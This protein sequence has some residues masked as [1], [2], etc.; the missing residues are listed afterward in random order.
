MIAPGRVS[1]RQEPS[2][3]VFVLI[4]WYNLFTGDTA[5]GGCGSTMS[6]TLSGERRSQL[7]ALSLLLALALGATMQVAAQPINTDSQIGGPR[8]KPDE[9]QPDPNKYNL[10]LDLGRY[11]HFQR[12]FAREEPADQPWAQA[13][14]YRDQLKL[15]LGPVTSMSFSQS[16]SA[17]RSY[18]GGTTGMDRTTTAGLTHGFGSG[19]T[20][21]QLGFTHEERVADIQGSGKAHTTSDRATLQAGLGGGL[22]FSGSAAMLHTTELAKP[23]TDA[24]DASIT[25]ASGVTLAEFHRARSVLGWSEAETSMMALRTPTLPVG[26]LGTFNAALQR[27]SAPGGVEQEV[28]NLSL[29]MPGLGPASLTATHTWS[30]TPSGGQQRVTNVDVAVPTVGPL[31]VT[32]GEQFVDPTDA[33]AQRTTRLGTQLALG[34]AGT[35]SYSFNDVALLGTGSMT[36]RA[37][38]LALPQSNGTGVGFRAAYTDFDGISVPAAPTIDAAVDYDDGSGLAADASYHAEAGMPQ[39]ELKAGAHLPIGAL[40][41][42]LGYTAGQWDAQRRV[43]DLRRIYDAGLSQTLGPSWSIS[44]GYRWIDTIVAPHEDTAMRFGVAGQTGFLGTIQLGYETATSWGLDI[45]SVQGARTVSFSMARGLGTD[46]SLTLSAKRLIP[47]VN[48]GQQPQE[49]VRADFQT[50]F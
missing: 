7:C 1:F 26:N 36:Q 23:S 47:P 2:R 35:L 9:Q 42:D 24:F 11:L 16:V 10:T 38:A 50:G 20:A 46:G 32:A 44:A 5:V 49:E 12:E 19:A 25:H 45:G 39:A 48:S 28:G 22:S 3:A 14:R 4:Q 37:Y 18:A 31:S 6:R 40:T 33:A 21:G 27:T 30:P 29:A 43:A 8:I 17:M 34:G 15:D 41:L 13:E